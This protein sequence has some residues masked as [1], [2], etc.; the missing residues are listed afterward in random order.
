M[1]WDNITIM[2]RVKTGT[3]ELGNDVYKMKPGKTIKARKNA[4]KVEPVT[5]NELKGEPVTLDERK[6]D[7][8]EHLFYLPKN[9]SVPPA[10]EYLKHRGQIY[11]V[12]SVEALTPR[13]IQVRA[14]HYEHNDNHNRHS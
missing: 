2:D 4:P 3:D 14:V 5:I 8:I 10:I 12:L 9:Q 13:F 11:R 7:R 1:I 6:V